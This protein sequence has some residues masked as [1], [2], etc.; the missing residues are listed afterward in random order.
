MRAHSLRWTQILFIAVAFVL[1]CLVVGDVYLHGMIRGSNN[2]N[3]RNDNGE[4]R[5]NANRLFD[6]QNNDKGGY[7]CPRAYPFTAENNGQSGTVNNKGELSGSNTINTPTY[8]VYGG[9]SVQLEWTNQHGAGLNPNMHSDVIWQYMTDDPAPSDQPLDV[10]FHG[11]SLLRDGTPINNNDGDNTNDEATTRI[12][13]NNGNNL[14][15]IDT[16]NLQ[17]G[18]YG[19]QETYESYRMCATTERNK[20]LFTADQEM[21]NRDTAQYTRQ[22]NDGTRYGLE[23]PEERDYYP[24]WRP[25]IWH[26][27]AIITSNITRCEQMQAPM[28]QNVVKKCQCVVSDESISD[29]SPITEQGCKNRPGGNWVCMSPW[30]DSKMCGWGKKTWACDEQPQCLLAS[31][32]RDN[33]LGNQMVEDMEEMTPSDKTVQ[34]ATFTWTVPEFIR[35]TKVVL[36]IRYNTSTTGDFD[37]DTADAALNGANSPIVDRNNR[38]ELSYVDLGLAPEGAGNTDHYKL[39]LAVNTDQHARTFQDRTYVF[40][41]KPVPKDIDHCRGK[42]K[43]L[44]VRGKRGNIVQTYP[45]VEYDFV[46]QDLTISEDDCL[47]AHWIGSDYNPNRNPNNAEGGPYNP[48][49]I[50]EA[51]ADRANIVQVDNLGAN[52]PLHLS[53]IQEKDMC[54]W[55]DNDNKCDRD[56]YRRFALLDQ[57]MSSCLTVA[58]LKEQGINNRNQRERDPRNCGKLN[59]GSSGSTPYFDG[60]VTKVKRGTYNFIS[61]RNNNFSNR[62]QKLKITVTPGSDSGLTSAQIAGITIGVLAAVGGLAFVSVKKGFISTD[63]I[64]S[65]GASSKKAMEKRFQKAPNKNQAPTRVKAKNITVFRNYTPT[66][67]DMV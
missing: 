31:Y 57:D 36:R 3:C 34:A 61:T 42:I 30:S 48:N 44:G 52:K 21:G 13:G 19:Y 18:R 16:A 9:S 63:S 5:R 11:N 65:I 25:S 41:V 6:S 66:S 43:N 53:L 39:S 40:I 29:P 47:H 20:G 8:Y 7:S 14:G 45:S 33:H 55:R 50:N 15:D 62:S 49:N 64:T 1:P 28:S 67:P 26:D 27:I 60:G 38:E 32:S 54:F 22:D 12:G 51:K 10:A 46:P 58:Q 59:G 2:R 35:E 24:Y 17:D 4:N 56:T 23:C 37:M